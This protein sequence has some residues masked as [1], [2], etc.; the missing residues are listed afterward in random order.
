VGNQRAIVKVQDGCDAHCTY[1]IIPK[2]RSVI[3][4]KP[5]GEVVQEV[6]NLVAAGHREVVLTGVFLGAYGQATTLRRRQV[7]EGQLG[8]LV[9]ALCTQ[10]PGLHRL[11]LSSLEPGDV[12]AG[13]VDILAKYPQVMPHFHLPL[14]SGSDAIL[15]KMNRQY[16]ASEYREMVSR[17]KAAFD[18]PAL[19]TDVIVGF[20]GEG[21]AEFAQT[22]ALAREVG[23]LHIHAFPYSPRTATAAARWKD[24]AIPQRLATERM[25]Q[26]EQLSRAL[27]LAYRRQFEGQ[28][29]RVLVERSR[30]GEVRHGR[31][32]RYFEVHFESPEELEGSLVEVEVTRV[33]A[34]RTT[35]RLIG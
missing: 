24:Q 35:G 6:R 27:S 10:V 13:L 32:E 26:L 28:T 23:F 18:R 19:T 34:V 31:C 5:A 14:Q 1:C 33:T 22:M 25:R 7:S 16:D 12:S 9:Q 8:P 17:L 3:W 21:E 30:G 11:R 29:V 20:P 2:L 4:S 15:R